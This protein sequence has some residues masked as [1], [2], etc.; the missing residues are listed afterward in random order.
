MRAF[1]LALLS[2]VFSAT[3]SASTGELR[4][5]FDSDNN[6]STGCTVGS[7]AGVDQVLITTVA[8]GTTTAAR[9]VCSGGTFGAAIPF[10]TSWPATDSIVES[11][12]PFEVL[13]AAPQMR[14]AI[15]SGVPQLWPPSLNYPRRHA[16]EPGA[17]P[18]LI[19]LDGEVKDWGNIAPFLPG[20]YL[21]ADT[22]TLWFRFDVSS[23]PVANDETYTVRQGKTLNVSAPGV[24]ANDTDPS[25]A[26]LSAASSVA[27]LHGTLVLDPTGAFTY[28]NNGSSAL[29]DSFKYKASNGSA[30]SNEATATINITPDKRPIAIADAYNVAHGGTLTVPPP[31]VLTNDSDP[32][33][34]RITAVI[35]SFPQHGT[36]SLAP[37]GGFTYTH[38]GSNS[39]ADSFTYRAFDSVLYSS[40][41]AV[42]L[43]IAPL[44]PAFTSGNNARMTAGT[45]TPF[46]VTTN[47]FPYP[48]ITFTGS[49]PSGVTLTDN[50]NGTATLGGSAVPGSGG[51]Y[52]L[53]LTATNTGGTAN[54]TFTL[55][56][57][58]VI[59]V[60]APATNSATAGAVFSQAFTQTGAVGSATFTTAS[61]V[62]AGLSL[63]AN[64]TL[65]GTPTVTGAFPIV[66]TVTDTNSCTGSANYTLTVGC[67]TITVTNPAT[68]SGTAG[69]AF[70]QAFT[71]SSAI[72]TPVFSTTSAL[73]AGLTL[74]S[75]GVLSGTPLVTGSFPIMVKVTDSNGCFGTGAIYT[76]MISCQTISVT[77]P[78]VTQA[79]VNASFSQTFTQSGAIG[80]ATFTTPSPLPTGLTL[81]PGGT[82]SGIPTGSGGVFAIVVTVT[83][84]NGCAGTGATYSLNVCPL[85]NVNNPGVNTGTAGAAF[86]QGFTNSGGNGTI[87][88]SE[89]GALPA[90][91]ALN[92]S[93]GLL[94]GT[95][96]VAGS[97]PITVTATDQNGCTGSS[98]YTL[99]IN[100]QTIGIT[101]PGVNTGTVDAAFS[102]TFTQSGVLGTATWSETGALPAGLT[103]NSSSGV[104]G[105]TPTVNGT[106]PI[107]VK[108]TDANGCFTT[109]SYTLTINC[110]TIAV[111]NPGANTGTV[112]AAFSQTF[113]QS[114]AHGTASFTTASTLPAG[115]SL[116]ASGVLSGTPTVNGSFPIVV[117]V[118]DSNGCAGTGATYTLT[119]NCQTISVTNAATTAGTVDAAFSQTFTQGGAHG[120]ATFSTAST[121]PAGL[122]LSSSG[123]L[124]GTPTVNGSFPIVVTVTDTNGCTGLGA[125]YNLV[126]NCQTITITNPV[127]TTGTVSAAFSEQF[128]QSGAHGT[129]TFTTASALPTGLSLSTS[130]LLSGTPM[131]AGSFPVVVTV[132]DSNGCTG[133]S[134]TY[135]LVINCQ[136]IFVI[137]PALTSSPAGT[138]ISI[139]FTQTGAIG[140]AAFT[141][142]STL[143]TGLTL[144]TDGTLSGTPTQGGTFPIAVTVT[145]SNGCTGTNSSYSLT[146]TCPTI[147]VTNPGVNSGTAGAAFSQTFTQSGGVGTITW[148]ESG[149]L[150]TGITL[151][152]ASGVL[153]G[154]TNQAGTFPITVTATDQNG[155]QG[156][157]SIYSLTI[158]CQTVSVTNPGVNSGTVDAAFSQTFT[159]SGILG[160]ATW[161]ETGALPA[162]LTLNSST[163]NLSGTPT[164]NGVFPITV[165]VT[166]T[167]G[168]FGT[169]SYILT[170]NCQTITVTNPGVNTGTVD[171]AFSQ[172][173]TQ[174][175]AHGAATFSTASTLPAG[176]TLSSSGTLS[177][178]PTVKGTFPIVV[179]VT[180]SNGCTGAGSTYTLTINCQVISV[181]NP[182]VSSGTTNAAF[183]QTFTQSAA[184]GSAAF[185]TASTLPTGF[186]LS[187][188]GVLSGTTQQHGTF[189]IVVTVTDANGCTGTGA[190]YNLVINCQTVTVTNP[191]NTSGTVNTAFSEQFSQS[192]GLAGGTFS[193]SSTLPNGLT[194]TG[195]TGILSGTPTQSG[196]FPIIVT[197]TDGNGCAGS[198]ATYSLVIGCQVITVN[199]PGVNTGT[200]GQAFSQAFTQ[201]NGVGTMTWSESGSL[202]GGITLDTSTGVLSGMT[203][204]VGSF[205]ITVTATD[206]NGCQG[207]GATY[208]LTI[209]C[210]TV[211]V[212]NPAQ[213]SFTAGTSFNVTFTSGGLLGPGT[214]SETGSL[215]SGISLGSGNGVL[216]GTTSQLGSFPITVKVTDS[217]GCFGTSSY[218]LTITCPT[219]TPARSGGGSFPSGTYNI[220]YAG[221][222]FVA[223]GGGGT[224]TFAVTGGALPT[225]LSLSSGGAI[226]GTPTATGTF[227]FT[228]TATDTASSCTGSAPFSIAIKPA[229]GGDSYS[230][231]VNNTE[232]VVTG[233]T[234][235]SPATPF[236]TLS[237][238]IIAN[239]LPSGGVA[240][241]GGTF[242]TNQSGSVTIAA[243][244]TFKYTPPAQPGVVPLTSDS[245]TYTISSDTGGTGTA[246]TAT[247][248]VSLTL[249][250]RVW[251][252]KNNGSNGNGQSQSP[253][254]S[255]SGFT[256][257]SRTTL[258]KTGD[259][260]YVFT[261]DTTSTNQN[262]GVV[263]LDNEQLVG[264]GAALVVNSQTLVG[265]G[266]KPVIGNAA[267]VGVTMA[268]G[269]TISGVTV[270]GSTSWGIT[271]LNVASGTVD[272]TTVTGN[273]GSMIVQNATGTFNIHSNVALTGLFSVAGGTCNVTND[274]SIDSQPGTVVANIS[275]W[276]GTTATFTGTITSSAMGIVVANNTAGTIT[277]SGTQTL[278]TTTNTAVGLSNN[279]GATISFSGSLGVTTSSGTGFT[280][281]GGGTLNVTGT[282]NV[283]TGAAG[284]GININGVIV[285]ASG[286]T[287]NAVNTTG[288]TTGVSLTSLGNGSVTIRSGTISGGTTGLSLSTLGT[289]TIT[290]G[291][292]AQTLTFTGST[293]AI[294]GSTFGTLAVASGSTVNVSGATGLNFSTG[295]VTG[296]FNN[297]SSTSGTNGVSLNAVT[298]SWGTTG[299]A[300]T[301]ASGATYKVVGGSGGTINWGGTIN[302]ANGAD[303]VNISGSNS[304]TINFS[305]NVTTS[306]T[307][308]GVSI[309]GSSGTYNF[310]G[311]T[312]TLAGS[313][314]GI[315]IFNESGTISFGSGYAITNASP[316]FK[317]GGTAT[318]TSANI[319]YAGNMTPAGGGGML[320]DVNSVAG[321]YNGNLSISGTTIGGSVGNPT[322]V[323]SRINNMTGSLTISNLNLTSNNNGFNNTLL[324]IGGT[325][326]A[327]TFTLNHLVLQANGSGHTGTGLTMSGGGTLTITATGGASSIDAGST[328][329]NLSGIALGNSTLATVNSTG[330]ANGIVLSNVSGGTF[331]ITGGS[332]AGST[333]SEVLVNG[334]N[335][336]TFSYG[337]TVT[338]TNQYLVDV[339]PTT[340]IT[341]GALTFSGTLG[342]ASAAAGLGLRVQNGSGGS[343]TFSGTQNL[344]TNVS[345]MASQ[346][347]TLASNTG[348]T[349]NFSGTLSIFTSGAAKGFN[350]TAGTVNIT[351]ASNTINTVNGTAVNW[352]NA[353]STSANTINTINS[354]G[355]GS[356]LVTSNTGATNFTIG[357]LTT[358]TGQAVNVTTGSGAFTFT[359]LS[360]GTAASGPTTG[361]HVQSLTGSFTV[362]GTGGLCDATHISG[363][364]CTGGTIQKSSARGMEFISSNNITLKNMYFKGNSTTVAGGCVGDVVTAADTSCNG[365]IFLQTVAGGATMDTI[366][367]DG[368]SQMGIITNGVA[369][370]NL[371]N[372]E[373]TNVGS[374]LGAEQSALC[375][376]NISGIC[377]MTGNHIHDDDWGHMIFITNN[378]GT[379]NI[380]FTNNTVDNVT[381]A[382]PNASD[383]FQAQAYGSANITV[384]VGPGAG[385]CNFTKLKGNGVAFG[386]SGASTMNGTLTNCTIFHTTGTLFQGSGTSNMTATVTNN[387]IT[388]KVS[389]DWVGAANG[390]HGITIGKSSGASAG[391]FTGIVTGNQVLKANCG[392]G[393]FGMSLN[394]YGQGTTTLTVNNNIVQHVDAYGIYYTAGQATTNSNGILTIQGNNLS[395]PDPGASYAIGMEIA[396]S[397]GDNVCLAAN[398]G[399]MS[400][401]HNVP[402]NRNTITNGVNN[403]LQYTSAGA[404]HQGT[405]PAISGIIDS[406]GG[407]VFK[408]F[409]YTGSTDTQAQ[410]WFV[411]SNSPGTSS[412][413]IGPYSGGT[414]CP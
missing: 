13:S 365:P 304:N 292:N 291:A 173:F 414:T 48:A 362:N 236:V 356:G 196:P 239:D 26:Q 163:G 95:T 240:A 138:P 302:Q 397:V 59:A 308:T 161:S 262:A 256:N 197:F 20:V 23:A 305:A 62:P 7:F 71:Q 287:F 254:N 117:M 158:S 221:Q 172:T 109:S 359:K 3:L 203:N 177:G 190:T 366:F 168:C 52:P 269:N 376:Q 171:A 131:Q 257:G 1:R 340:G 121:L 70:S 40:G 87:T 333:G 380:T 159:S 303:V 222:S 185:T 133:T 273:S 225:G 135:N 139:K 36:V 405:G 395:N 358:A 306:T 339:G 319:T 149:A 29:V 384:L 285:G 31:G 201:S 284:N 127:N 237:G 288:A 315:T 353:T 322:G 107:M 180:D 249:A 208:I 83:D 349:I 377:N 65:S 37:T 360:S 279:T 246:T 314:A 298:G 78:V 351:G 398:I 191:V 211:T 394:G 278:N 193:T 151:N 347:V 261:G 400:P 214:W 118:T 101:N 408:L 245:F 144:A 281:T 390:S 348:S 74:S 370:F 310:T 103:L 132:T 34:D 75:S 382:N 323:I 73:P 128:T 122:T 140:T 110:Q 85:I 134:A 4:V 14:I 212:T 162:G 260:I 18:Q 232:A 77:N 224:Y 346:A 146:L 272:A 195:S 393:C 209:N 57:C 194:L 25:G 150:P 361:V 152:T 265:A 199:N 88:W 286:A 283:T 170:I 96:S 126:I 91:I 294:S 228:V 388:N 411:A 174:S 230:N 407:T 45:S 167:N 234:T 325:N 44:A 50:G 271:A 55:T 22:T 137:N 244:G 92:A 148:S 329:L 268:N 357:T 267:G 89:T 250:G 406:P 156:T 183:S 251:Y 86:S 68:N 289:S 9:Q 375:L 364:D 316:S 352:T 67:Q 309:S 227:A 372:S 383:G 299:G 331:T 114:G 108:V 6:G 213:N 216:S 63:A 231:L 100:C 233:G 105:G 28:A 182:V 263:L 76:L 202:P 98:G 27:P 381:I 363:T 2:C 327:G 258:D 354:T 204:Q 317:I 111:T 11:Y 51:V 336:P 184:H 332:L 141:T 345:N 58:N 215:P 386:S 53:T 145:D 99:T 412:D 409:N 338:N 42:S 72:G 321:T 295:A 90:G 124:G 8:N 312:S 43:T 276:S 270:S 342:G 82:L 5:L 219:I 320:I 401:L 123:V 259:I 210:N 49:L 220:A 153:S 112:D 21:F 120:T 97:F 403:W 275:G 181:T 125:T 402:A 389:T 192:G 243:D 166:D 187:A 155:C 367:V 311:G 385:T 179:T 247:G 154:T 69:A 387:I 30:T 143:P 207:T 93:N 355:S 293:T 169:S 300:L 253:F 94:S 242:S 102:Q 129:A 404:G 277:F 238:S 116:S 164:V 335:A 60:T 47:G 66:V 186:S 255:L 324:A 379:A 217:N 341:N 38:D 106:F 350:T 79:T 205:P 115:L 136:T 252:V 368:S 248:T 35:A 396:T 19:T 206:A 17:E 178:T 165:K 374:V 104:L 301:G 160:T 10:G 392:G 344:G 32:D 64:G 142:A 378:T 410:A 226:S 241:V 56:V 290:L 223:T 189:P 280:A 175:A 266:T 369:G 33:G 54:Q 328:A 80:G 264:Q 198:S 113:T 337:G 313:G 81:A 330:G 16:S 373:V 61:G 15:N 343:V 296:T 391:T 235:T 200:A 39:L 399:D 147:N 326:T 229:T 318:N 119:I 46:T 307:S 41:V 176:L 371:T 188:G 12:I 130:G 84:G 24:L 334:A 297:V 218:T 157:G 413:S 282:A 274:A